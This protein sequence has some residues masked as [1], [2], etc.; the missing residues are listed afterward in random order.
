MKEPFPSH[1]LFLPVRE[2]ITYETRNE[3]LKESASF[4]RY[5]EAKNRGGFE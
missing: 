5:Q 1:A 4:V 2:I 3:G